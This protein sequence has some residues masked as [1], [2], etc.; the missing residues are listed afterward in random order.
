M[1]AAHVEEER[2]LRRDEAL[3]PD[4]HVGSQQA[5]VCGDEEVVPRTAA[6]R[7]D[8]RSQGLV[9][10]GN[11]SGRVKV[12][13]DAESRGP[14]LRAGNAK[15]DDGHAQSKKP[16]AREKTSG[17]R[18]S[19]PENQRQNR[20]DAQRREVERLEEPRSHDPL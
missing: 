5:P 8:Q 7:R 2:D 18:Q 9:E 16:V 3:E 1:E 20:K 11:E 17:L 19:V 13:D 10:K 15:R 12:Q 4:S 6:S 14:S